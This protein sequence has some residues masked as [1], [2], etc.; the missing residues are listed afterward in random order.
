M[1]QTPNSQLIRS[2]RRGAGFPTSTKLTTSSLPRRASTDCLPIVNS[3]PLRLSPN[4]SREGSST[5]YTSPVSSAEEIT[6]RTRTGNSFLVST[7]KFKTV[8]DFFHLTSF[9]NASVG[10][11]IFLHTL[12]RQLAIEARLL[13]AT[14]PYSLQRPLRALLA[15]MNEPGRNYRKRGTK[16]KRLSASS[17]E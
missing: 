15:A 17:A 14:L 6:P 8:L 11:A 3:A 13:A 4:P 1:P 10:E 5:K 2:S 9:E 7:V 12:Y 16:R